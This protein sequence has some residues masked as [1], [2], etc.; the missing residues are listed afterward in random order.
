MTYFLAPMVNSFTSYYQKLFTRLQM[1]TLYTALYSL[2][3]QVRVPV[4][5]AGGCK[6]IFTSNPTSVEV[7]LGL[8]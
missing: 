1:I 5:W 6:V 2:L 4:G 7:V 3:D 8:C